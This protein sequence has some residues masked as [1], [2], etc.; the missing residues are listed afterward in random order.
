MV[1]VIVAGAG[2][3]GLSTAYHLKKTIPEI[4]VVVYAK[5]FS[6][7]LTS[8]GA[9]GLWEPYIPG[10]TSI[11]LV[12]KW[13]QSTYDYVLD[14]IRTDPDSGNYGL[15]TC[16]GYNCSTSSDFQLPYWSSI[17]LDYHLLNERDVARRFPSW[18]K[19]AASFTSVFIEGTKYLP[20][21]TKKFIELGGQLCQKE[22]YSLDEFYEECDVFVNCTGLG[23]KKLL[24]DD[25]L[26]TVRG[27]ILKVK[28][29]SIKEFLI[30]FEDTGPEM[31][32]YVLPNQDYVILGGTKQLNN[33]DLTPNNEDREFILR[34][35]SSIYPCLKSAEVLQEWVGLRPCRKSMRV[36][37]EN[38]VVKSSIGSENILKVVHN[39]GHGGS[40]LTVH[41][42][43][44]LETVKLVQEFLTE[45]KIKK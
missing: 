17:P 12:S 32:T 10:E 36:E 28:A 44:A 23:S 15:M 43:C 33:Y 2:I 35:T 41:W 13:S 38:F 11:E 45:I 20:Y 14:K 6:P 40:G 34:T 19:S 37:K 27:H 31:C 7:N 42:G 1:K 25:E 24:K 30:V 26:Y 18:I 8:D 9:A 5:D 16:L 39:Y 22:I 3:M 4:D 29:N 21:L